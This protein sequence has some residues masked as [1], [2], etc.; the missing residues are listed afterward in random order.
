MW[1]LRELV[2]RPHVVETLD[3]LTHGPMTFS[4]L[5]SY[6]RRGRRGLSDA[7]R[8]VAARGLVTRTDSGSW[9]T[10][11]PADTIYRLTEA[12][13]QVVDELSNFTVWTAI[14]DRDDLMPH[15]QDHRGHC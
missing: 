14:Y 10:K 13:A 8:S 5:R 3:A 1:S 7:L 11:P 2:N 15:A 6:V 12:G 9:D 4:E